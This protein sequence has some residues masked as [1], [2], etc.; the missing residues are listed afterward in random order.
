MDLKRLIYQQLL[1]SICALLVSQF[2]T[3]YLN[4]LLKYY[5]SSTLEQSHYVNCSFLVYTSSGSLSVSYTFTC[6]LSDN[7]LQRRIF[8]CIGTWAP[9]PSPRHRF[10]YKM[11]IPQVEPLLCEVWIF[12]QLSM[13]N[14]DRSMAC[15]LLVLLYLIQTIIFIDF[16]YN[17]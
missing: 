4:I 2:Y 12:P 14:H 16:D 17:Q 8:L 15:F 7:L 10:N 3:Q 13:V 6:T 11:I 9:P 5:L 1:S